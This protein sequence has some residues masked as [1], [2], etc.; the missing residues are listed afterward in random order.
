MALSQSEDG[1][2]VRSRVSLRGESTKKLPDWKEKNLHESQEQKD[3]SKEQPPVEPGSSPQKKRARVECCVSQIQRLVEDTT[4]SLE[5]ANCELRR[6]LDTAESDAN[7]KFATAVAAAL[8]PLLGPSLTPERRE[9]LAL[10]A[11]S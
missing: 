1:E 4:A 7:Q 2:R 3:S 11:S 8:L 5:D 9:A 6:R 10:L